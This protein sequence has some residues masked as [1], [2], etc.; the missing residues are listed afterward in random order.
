MVKKQLFPKRICTIC[1]QT[2]GGSG[3]SRD[4]PQSRLGEGKLSGGSCCAGPDH[5]RRVSWTLITP[6]SFV[7]FVTCFILESLPCLHVNKS[8]FVFNTGTKCTQCTTYCTYFECECTYWTYCA[9]NGPWKWCCITPKGFSNR[10]NWPSAHLTAA[11]RWKM[12]AY[13]HS[14]ETMH[15][16]F[17]LISESREIFSALIWLWPCQIGLVIFH[18]NYC[19]K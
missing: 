1:S 17:R 12:S 16:T 3:G 5:L 2:E 6:P 18:V 9:Y 7:L 15:L 19:W 10:R 13:K 11:I 4:T 8:V 14:E